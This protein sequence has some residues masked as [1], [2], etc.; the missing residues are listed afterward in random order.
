V[1]EA[2]LRL[3]PPQRSQLEDLQKEVDAKLNTILTDAQKTQL[4]ALRERGPGGFG[5][6]G[7]FGRPRRGG[8][9]GG[10]PPPGDG[11]A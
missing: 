9:P 1:I 8:P 3:T 7:G 2:R 10:G 4:K 11:P 5:P 6:P